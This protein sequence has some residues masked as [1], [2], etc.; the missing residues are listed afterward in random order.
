MSDLAEMWPGAE[1]RGRGLLVAV[2][3]SNDV[4]SEI[5]ERA[6]EAGLVLNATSP[7]TLRFAPPLVITN[8]QL[9]DALATLEEVADAVLTTT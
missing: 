8:E 3:F 4:A 9:D 1:V 5:V 7:N 2:E 6:L